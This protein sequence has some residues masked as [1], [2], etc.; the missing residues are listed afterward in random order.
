ML[1]NPERGRQ[2]ASIRKKINAQIEETRNQAIVDRMKKIE[3]AKCPQS[4]IFKIRRERNAVQKIGFPL[5]DKSGQI[6]VTKGGIDRVVKEHFQK[7]FQ[8]NPVPKG[9][10]WEEYWRTVDEVFNVIANENCGNF[11]LPTFEEIKLLFGQLTTG[12]QFLGQ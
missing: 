8:Q 3:S 5:K 12:N 9:K 7:V 2:I 4:E 10:I 11:E 6:Q 1:E